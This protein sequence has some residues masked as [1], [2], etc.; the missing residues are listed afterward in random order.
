MRD[1]YLILGVPDK[2]DDATVEKAYLDG[3]KA[4]P[5]ERDAARFQA[6]RTAYE[7]LR[8][9]RD[10]FSYTLFDA[11]PPEIADLLDRMA[12]TGPPRRPER[13]LLEAVLEGDD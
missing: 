11:S 13:A 9:H 12:P 3:I 6:L 4:C 8:T 2:A 7:Q 10:R 5:P 1:P